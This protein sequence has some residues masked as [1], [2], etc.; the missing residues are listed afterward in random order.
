MRSR[1][2]T[3]GSR[4]LL[5][6]VIALGF[7]LSASRPSEGRTKAWTNVRGEIDAKRKLNEIRI[8]ATDAT[9]TCSRRPRSVIASDT[10]RLEGRI[11][12]SCAPGDK[13]VRFKA[14]RIEFADGL[15]IVCDKSGAA[16]WILDGTVHWLGKVA[17]RCDADTSNQADSDRTSHTPVRIA[18][19]APD[20]IPLL[21]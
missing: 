17:V 1:A 7:A 5:G 4:L 20:F 13:P 10:I 15:R 11:S 3:G 2:S 21:S 19:S 12:F 14:P 18:A 8:R 16:S 9:F 6:V